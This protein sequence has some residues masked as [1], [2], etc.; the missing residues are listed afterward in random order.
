M[1]T[2]APRARW[3]WTCLVISCRNW[4]N[5][6]LSFGMH[7]WWGTSIVLVFGFLISRAREEMLMVLAMS[8]RLVLKPKSVLKSVQLRTKEKVAQQNRS[9]KRTPK[10]DSPI[11]PRCRYSALLDI[12]SMQLYRQLRLSYLLVLAHQSLTLTGLESTPIFMSFL[13]VP[14]AM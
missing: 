14:V 8:D 4:I 10:Q 12:S 6:F 5:I 3:S 11:V 1:I 7:Q 13:S 2:V 9:F